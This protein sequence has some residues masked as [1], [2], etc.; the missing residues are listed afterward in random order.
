MPETI[1]FKIHGMDCADEVVLLKKEVGPLVGGEDKLYFNILEGK[2]TVSITDETVTIKS[3]R[4][5]V[6][7]TGMEAVPWSEFCDSKA[8]PVEEGFWK[9]N[10]R[11]G[12]CTASGLFFLMG[13]AVHGY[14]HSFIDALAASGTGEHEFPLLSVLFYLSAVVTGGWFI[15]PKAVYAARKLRPDMNLLMAIA[16]IGAI[17]IDEWFEAAAVTFLFSLA[18]LLESWSVERARKA[19]K[20]LVGLSPLTARVVSLES[21]DIVERRVD[22]VPVG[23]VIVIRPGDKI[24]LDGVITKGSTSVDQAPITGESIPVNKTAGDEVFAGTINGVGAFEFKSTKV[25][26]DTT[27]SRI[28]QLVEEAQSHRAPSEQWVEKFARYYTPAMIIL[29]III[30]VIPPLIFGGAWGDWFYQALVILVIACP[31]ALVISTP[32]SIVAGLTAAAKAGVLIKGGAYLEIPAQLNAIALDKTGTLTYGRPAVQE[33]V[34]LNGH[35]KK[36]LIGYAA[37]LEA[38]S[39]HPLAHAILNEAES[40]GIDITR[41]ENFTVMQGKGATGEIDGRDYWIGSHRLMEEKG[42]EDG[43]THEIAVA[44]EDAGHSIVCIFSEKH[45]C[46]LISIADTVRD[47]ARE[48][49]QSLKALGIS[50]IVMLTGDNKRTAEA[51]ASV[52]NVD[53]YKSE[54]LPEDKVKELTRLTESFGKTAMVGDGVNDAP[55]MA[56]STIGIAMGV[57]GTDAAIETADIALMTDD[58]RKLPWLI[59]HSRRTL[60]VVKQNI[61][62]A[63]GLKLVFII[64]ALVGAATLWMAIAADM[65]ASLLV[66]FNGLRLLR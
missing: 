2:M 24:P 42:I 66:I 58:L 64:L 5:T 48:A 63:L 27:L 34:P 53:S 62:F 57:M 23:T 46:G 59:K 14:N 39:T 43:K 41:A 13:F 40:L 15:A 32:V 7:H 1:S 11:A 50:Q 51:V 18:L 31:C 56:A 49:V 10:G 22:E 60:R 28:I 65:G 17:I 45:V 36:Q 19:I 4:Q 30:A 44:L 55:A 33:V 61:I 37:A 21:G 20:A 54:L 6:A 52:I 35:T 38:H 26:K 29:A 16:A 3:I 25:A 12:A 8:C 47:E 9:R